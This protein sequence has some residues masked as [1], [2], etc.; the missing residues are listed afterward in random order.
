M[1]PEKQ[2][3]QAD[4]DS[5]STYA[6]ENTARGQGGCEVRKDRNQVSP[7]CGESVAASRPS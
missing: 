2:S 1:H 4:K 5:A 6:P 7:L 3:Q